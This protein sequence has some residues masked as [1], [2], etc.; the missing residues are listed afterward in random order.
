[1]E[2]YGNWIVW[3]WNVHRLWETVDNPVENVQNS[4]L[5]T[6]LTG[7]SSAAPG[8]GVNRYPN[9]RGILCEYVKLR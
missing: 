9:I 1:M 4:D 2:R 3:G 7:F 6:V 5:S 8:A